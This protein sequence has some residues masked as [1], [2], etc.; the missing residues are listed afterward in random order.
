MTTKNRSHLNAALLLLCCSTLAF[1][2]HRSLLSTAPQ[3]FADVVARSQ[4]AVVRIVT[5]RVTAPQTD[6]LPTGLN[7]PASSPDVRSR[8]ISGEG[9]G[10]IIS[11]DGYII[12][13]HHVIDNSDF[14]TVQLDDERDLPARLIASDPE[15]DLAVIK[16]EAQRLPVLSFGD[17]TKIRPGDYTLAIGNP[18]GI[19]TAVSLGIVS[20]KSRSGADGPEDLIQ[21]DAAINPGNSGGPL[22][23]LNGDLI[24]INTAIVTPSG[25]SSGVGFAIPSNLVRTAMTDLVTRGKVSHGYLGVG[26]QPMTAALSEA[27]GI[28]KSGGALLADVYAGSPAAKAGLAKGDVLTAING[29]AV[30]DFSRL[31][32]FVAAARPDSTIRLTAIRDSQERTFE[33]HLTERP[34]ATPQ[35]AD[36]LPGAAVSEVPGENSGVVV[37]AVD[38]DGSSAEAGLRPGDV[39]VFA[40]RKPA[41]SVAELRKALAGTSASNALLEINRNGSSFFFAVPR[42]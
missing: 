18:F 26:M 35:M 4:P 14:I 8:R 33:V 38:P 40:N 34:A 6:R 13:N 5:S 9:S 19:G 17:S 30:R 1:S 31:R 23:D 25:A 20:A 32:Y 2:E 7:S 12:T 27:M 37:V 16:V 10:V 22:V 36:I 39:I 42:S 41:A 11:P 29:R 24:G 3:G 15:L 21:T 28:G